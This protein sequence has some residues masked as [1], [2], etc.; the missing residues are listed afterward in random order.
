ML[1]NITTGSTTR[2]ANVVLASGSAT[3]TT[4]NTPTNGGKCDHPSYIPRSTTEMYDTC[5][6]CG[7]K[8]NATPCIASS[9]YVLTMRPPPDIDVY[10]GLAKRTWQPPPNA[11]R[12]KRRW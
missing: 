11:P 6:V 10:T 2:T 1:D 9:T 7:A 5:T 12:A 3:S 8:F 4:A